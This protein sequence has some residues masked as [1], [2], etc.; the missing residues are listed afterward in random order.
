MS[1]L[2]TLLIGLLVGAVIFY[3]VRYAMGLLS[4]PQPIQNVVLVILILIAIVWILQV[5]GLLAL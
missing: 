3:L 2:I 5:F 4:V 1:L